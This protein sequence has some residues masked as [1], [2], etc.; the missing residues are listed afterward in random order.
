MILHGMNHWAAVAEKPQHLVGTDWWAHRLQ[1]LP[2]ISLVS[3]ALHGARH[4][5]TACTVEL[6]QALLPAAACV[7]ASVPYFADC[8][9]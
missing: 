1:A 9:A 2:C 8:H 5:C 6:R 7:H 4:D 3:D